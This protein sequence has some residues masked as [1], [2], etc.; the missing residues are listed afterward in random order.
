MIQYA[1]RTQKQK[2]KAPGPSAPRLVKTWLPS[3]LVREMDRTILASGGSYDGRDD[4]IREAITDR[5]ADERMRPD[6]GPAAVVLLPF[7]DDGERSSP[8]SERIAPESGGQELFGPIPA[9]SLSTLP[10]SPGAD[11]LYGLHNRDYPTLWVAFSLIKMVASNRGP[12]EW[13]QFADSIL[14]GAWKLGAHLARLDRERAQH[15]MKAAV[16]FPINREKRQSSEARFMAHM[17]GSASQVGA[18]SG[19]LFAMQLAGTDSAGSG[20][21]MVAP[22]EEGVALCR[23]L[24]AS[25]LGARPPHTE[26]A[27]RAFRNHLKDRLP[28]DYAAWVRVLKFL[29]TGPDRDALVGHFTEEWSGAAAATNVGG[30]VSRGREW[31][32]VEHK[33]VDGHYGLTDRGRLEIGVRNR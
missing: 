26:A 21:M 9:G 11:S 32:L 14:E 1:M 18:P 8:P 3:S 17:A 30:Y 2:E 29:A 16:G 13:S 33:L 31:G 27:W 12:I 4:F 6:T 20:Q 24:V 28:E 10:P 23:S 19:P 15:E 25:G 7:G 22:T 5:L